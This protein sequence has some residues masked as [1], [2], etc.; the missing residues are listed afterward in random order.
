[1]KL[2]TDTLELRGI[3]NSKSNKGNVY[4]IINCEEAQDGTPC[5]FYC[6]DSKALPEG[7]KKGDKVRLEVVY[8]KFKNLSVVDVKKVG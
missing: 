3:K 5:Q 8:D 6:P 7:L 1:M 2:I 4:Y